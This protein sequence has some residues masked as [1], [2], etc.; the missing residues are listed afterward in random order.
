MRANPVRHL[1]RLRT[2][3]TN[4]F[5]N[6]RGIQL[7]IVEEFEDLSRRYRQIVDRENDF[8]IGFLH[9]QADWDSIPSQELKS[10]A[11]ISRPFGV[12]LHGRTHNPSSIICDLSTDPASSGNSGRPWLGLLWP[13]HYPSGWIL[14]HDEAVAIQLMLTEGR[15]Y[16]KHVRIPCAAGLSGPNLNLE[17]PKQLLFPQDLSERVGPRDLFW[18]SR[19]RM[20]VRIRR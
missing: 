10:F 8:A 18:R 13:K 17:C 12:V 7:A 9:R 5:A 1:I 15:S 11:Y 19:L 20:I 16:C 3:V 4:D 14:Y 2:G 6:R